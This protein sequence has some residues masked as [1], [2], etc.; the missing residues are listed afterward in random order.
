MKHS[1][2]PLWVSKLTNL[3]G[4]Q[5]MKRHLNDLGTID[6]ALM[7]DVPF[8]AYVKDLTGYADRTF[9]SGQ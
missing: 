3:E 4:G 5:L 7:T 2:Q 8:N 6:P 1:L 9:L